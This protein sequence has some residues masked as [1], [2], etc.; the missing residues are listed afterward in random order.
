MDPDVLG[1]G[2]RLRSSLEGAMGPPQIE[3]GQEGRVQSHEGTGA[4]LFL[5][6]VLALSI[7]GPGAAVCLPPFLRW[8]GPSG[9]RGFR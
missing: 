1:D 3:A 8:P 5:S 9:R 7:M 2:Q 4:L 6:N